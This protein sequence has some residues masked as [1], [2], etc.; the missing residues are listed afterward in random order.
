M[1]GAG[2]ELPPIVFD[3]QT[4][5]TIDKPGSYFVKLTGPTFAADEPPPETSDV[6]FFVVDDSA[7][8][9]SKSLDGIF[10][11]AEICAICGRIKG[12][13]CFADPLADPKGTPPRRGFS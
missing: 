13:A 6:Y 7:D 2:E 4:L 1:L 12:A 3:L 10:Q 9:T 5:F 8:G 11:S